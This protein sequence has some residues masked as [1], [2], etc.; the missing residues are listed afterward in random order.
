[1]THEYCFHVSRNKKYL[2]QD[3]YTEHIQN[4]SNEMRVADCERRIGDHSH[5]TKKLNAGTFRTA[6]SEQSFY[7]LYV[8][9]TI[10]AWEP[11]FIQ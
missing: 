2:Y 9:K 3:L 8:T 11:R 10:L 5:I 7:N 4:P 1:M 6:I